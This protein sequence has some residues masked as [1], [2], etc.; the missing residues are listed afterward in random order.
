MQASDDI[1]HGDG[2]GAGGGAPGDD[3]LRGKAL[4][5]VVDQ[6][7]GTSR[8]AKYPATTTPAIATTSAFAA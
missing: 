3:P 2:H 5:E 4:R 1:E 7:R 8:P 6:F